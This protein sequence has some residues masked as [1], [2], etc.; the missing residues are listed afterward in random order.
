MFFKGDNSRLTSLLF[1]LST[2]QLYGTEAHRIFS[3][4]VA[5]TAIVTVIRDTLTLTSAN[6]T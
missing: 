2:I 3:I 4:V 1:T 6:I 5:G